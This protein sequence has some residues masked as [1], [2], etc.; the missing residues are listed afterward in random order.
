MSDHDRANQG[1]QEHG[2][3]GLGQRRVGEPGPGPRQEHPF[4]PSAGGPGPG[5]GDDAA[6]DS[7]DQSPGRGRPAGDLPE[8]PE[9]AA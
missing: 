8:A 4:P 5:S 7:E 9:D 3:E 6:T 2:S 1:H